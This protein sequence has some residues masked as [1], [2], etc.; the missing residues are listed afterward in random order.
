MRKPE[1]NF[2]LKFTPE[3]YKYFRERMISMILSTDMA[4]HFTDLSK[5]KARLASSGNLIKIYKKPK[6]LIRKIKIKVSAWIF[7]YMLQ[8][9]VIPSN[10]SLYMKNGLLESSRNSGFKYY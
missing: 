8:I 2:A 5:L 4:Y 1:C 7:F 10:L 3:E 6:N 9:S